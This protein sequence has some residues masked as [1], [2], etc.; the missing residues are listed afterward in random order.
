MMDFEILDGLA[1]NS[2]RGRELVR[3]ARDITRSAADLTSRLL[4]FSRRQPL[5]PTTVDLTD[6]IADTTGLLRRTLGETVEIDTSAPTDLWPVKVDRGQL[7]SSI[8]NLALNARDAMPKGGRLA[9]STANFSKRAGDAHPSPDLATG[10][11]VRIEVRDTGSGMS[12]EVVSRAF[13]PFFTTKAGSGTGL[14]LASV[15]GFA[16]QS[17]GNV[18]IESAIGRGTTVTLFL[19]RALGAP[20]EDA[21]RPPR[22]RAG[23]GEKI[24]VVEDD[25]RLR[26]RGR[27][28]LKELG[29]ATLEAANAIEALRVLDANSDIALLFTDT[30][31]P[32]GTDGVQ[33]ARKAK[34][35]RPRLKVLLT[36]GYAEYSDVDLSTV[37]EGVLR[38]PYRRRELAERIRAAL[39]SE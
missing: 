20:E 34:A 4:A 9:I 30:V 12:E 8:L 39:D 14:G 19:P 22:L 35:R 31:M 10:D 29:Y 16:R 37:S 33:L 5:Q 15:Y 2:E 32:G 27:A 24:L 23:G 21:G 17:G 26:K 3:E 36:S 18:Q 1:E 13:E 11:Y 38:K 6:L 28:V 25:E 7:E